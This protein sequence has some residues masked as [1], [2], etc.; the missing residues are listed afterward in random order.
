MAT[1]LLQD[2]TCDGYDVNC[3]LASGESMVFHFPSQPANVQTS[4]DALE[5][6]LPLEPEYIIEGE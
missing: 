3:L 1:I 5:A 2:K 6:S 4:V